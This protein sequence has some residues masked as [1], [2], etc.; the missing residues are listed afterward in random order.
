MLTQRNLLTNA[1]RNFLMENL[2]ENTGIIVPNLE[3]GTVLLYVQN[4]SSIAKRD[5][6]NILV[7]VISFLKW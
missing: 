6:S 7:N 4:L 3:L 5:S 1:Y 2:F